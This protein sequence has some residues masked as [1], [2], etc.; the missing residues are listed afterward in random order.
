M[1][2]GID[3]ELRDLRVV[4]RHGDEMPG[5]RLRIAAQSAEG[6]VTRRM[7]IGHRLQRREGL[8]RDDEQRL[9]RVELARRLDEIG[10]VDVGHETE[11]HRPFAVELERFIRHHRSQV[12]PANADVDHVAD[13][14]PR[15]TLPVATANAVGERRHPVE[16]RVHIGNDV[17]PIDDDRGTARR[18]Q[19]HMQHGAIL[20]NVDPVAA[21][22]EIAH[23]HQVRGKRLP[24][25]PRGRWGNGSCHGSSS[26]GFARS[27]PSRVPWR[28][29]PLP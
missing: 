10:A 21:E 13:G 20:G 18:A 16:H 2:S 28:C 5:H 29:C 4:G 6:P 27:P 9:G 26:F 8:R 19:R 14:L 17:A 12:G 1:F 11:G 3:A 7:R 24:R 25:R 22:L 23:D 15:M